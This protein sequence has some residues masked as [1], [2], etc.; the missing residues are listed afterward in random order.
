[1]TDERGEPLPGASVKVKGSSI[2]TVTDDGGNFVLLNLPEGAVLEIG[3]VGYKLKVTAIPADTNGWTIRLEA[4]VA[5]L[6]EVSV[7]STGYQEIPK[8]R[9]TGSFVKINRELLN[10]RVGTNILDRLD[11]ITSGLIFNNTSTRTLNDK[12]GLNIRGRSTIDDKVN[13]SPL[14]VVDNFPYEGDIDNINPNDIESITVL[15]DAAAAS[16]WGARAG[17]GVIVITTRKGTYNSGLKIE[18]NTNTTIGSKPD[19][20]YSPNYLNASEYI[21]LERTLFNQ[22][23]FDNDLNNMITRPVLS[24][25]VELLAL[26]RSN[27]SMAGDIDKQVNLLKQNDI[28]NDFSKYIYRSTV[29]QQHSISL[30]GGS[31]VASYVLSAGYDK[32]Q[33]ELVRNG[34]S[35]IT[36]NSYSSFHPVKNLDITAGINYIQSEADRNSNEFDFASIIVGN[37]WGPVFPYAR[38]ADDNGAGLSIPKTYRDGYLQDAENNGFLDWQYDPLDEIALAD[39]T[40][41]IN[42]I[43]LK[44]GIK[45]KLA[46][47]LNTQIQYQYERQQTDGRNYR[48]QD[49]YYVRNLINRFSQRNTNGSFTYPFPIGG[50]LDLSN[51]NLR[52]NNLR[53][54]VNYNQN[55]PKEHS[56]N[57]IGGAELRD[58]VTTGYGRTSYGY[59]DAFGTSVSNLN[60]NT[61][62]PVQPSGTSTISSPSSNV[63]GAT[64]RFISYYLSGSYSYKSRYVF[65]LSGRK[66]GANI[67]G[68]KTNDKIVPLWSAGLGYEISQ[69]EFYHLSFLPFLKLRATYGF[70]GNVYNASAYLT[71]QYATSNLT[72]LPYATI[73]S[74]PNAELRW[75]RVKNINI[76]LDFA[77]RANRFSGTV[78]LFSKAGLDLIENVPL[79]PSSGFA[80]FKGNA[81]GTLTRGIDI[82]L[83]TRVLKGRLQ[84]NNSFLLSY[85]HDEVTSYDPTQTGK[86]LAADFTTKNAG[87]PNLLRPVV[88]RP[89]F[90]IFSYKWAG[91][92]PANGDPQGYLDGA[93]S[94]DYTNIINTATPDNLVFHGSGRPTLYGGFRNTFT[95]KGVSLSANITY[96][97]G[98]YF[99]RTSTTLNYQNVFGLAYINE[100]YSARWQQA[101]D[102]R[103]TDVPSL[104]YPSNTNRDNFYQQS[105]SLVERGDHIRLQDI[106]IGYAIDRDQWK[107]SPFR[108]I[109]PYLYARN[110]GILWRANKNGIDPDQLI[111][112]SYPEPRTLALGLRIGI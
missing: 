98:Y 17:N 94:K 11:G 76:G 58:I 102:E 105:E 64:N 78:E 41:K 61:S 112:R 46:S 19:L 53:W 42:N 57:A 3:Y 28:R 35:R 96:K 51:N 68:V 110:L 87:F 109:Q 6:E 88:G 33:E 12:L 101:G 60:Y 52:S 2:S 21:E 79:A 50:I 108:S 22:G 86:N 5:K 45:Y 104:V 27:P 84:W 75:E 30:T 4:D 97:L 37:K 82:T 29:K 71:A 15:K 106:S 39:N 18:V 32:N 38:L 54:Q 20:F 55:L 73:T 92:D 91:L 43:V 36:L 80:N 77:T 70:N 85:Q 1:M 99:R 74:P 14:I 23:L 44:A 72:G 69:E 49:T 63:T 47:F 16:I 107:K 90:S 111:I 89:L 95:W 34:Y 48:S 103:L 31:A 13:A 100:D 83:N 8:E 62:Y 26:A 10:R 24:P 66:D 59:D 40:A 56:I 81:A 67:F 93:V 7:V 25:V 9:A 65:S